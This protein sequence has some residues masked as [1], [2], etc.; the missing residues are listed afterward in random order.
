MCEFGRG[1][2]RIVVVAHATAEI[3][4]KGRQHMRKVVPSEIGHCQ[5]AE[6]VIQHAGRVLDRIIADHEPRRFE[7]GKG[8]RIHEFLQRHAILQANGNRDGEIIH[9]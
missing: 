6:N 4:I 1:G 3:F 5:L 7:A 9:Q 8:E 2:T